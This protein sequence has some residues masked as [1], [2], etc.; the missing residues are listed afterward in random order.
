MSE[1]GVFLTNI[2]L[3]LID[4][5][6]LG[7]IGGIF[8]V[9]GLAVITMARNQKPNWESIL[10][11]VLILLAAI[12]LIRWYPRQVIMSIRVA[13][14]ESRPEA[15]LLREELQL[16]LPG[17]DAL[18][19][20]P[21]LTPV[22][23]P[24]TTLPSAPVVGPAVPAIATPVVVLGTITVATAMPATPTATMYPTY[25]PWPTAT[26]LP[27]ATPCLVNIGGNWLA[28]PPTPVIGGE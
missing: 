15:E 8:Y 21:V 22:A 4:L 14:Q 25:T 28:C 24:L 11:T 20:T 18:I 7:L 16:W 3:F 10:Y 13:L 5:A 1:A 26:A 9:I 19:A 17:T 27:T 2:L 12:W 23:T 6:T